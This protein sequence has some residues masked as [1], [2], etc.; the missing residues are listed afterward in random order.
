M[1]FPLS[2]AALV[3][4]LPWFAVFADDVA[5][6]GKIVAKVNGEPI[7]ESELAVALPEGS[8]GLTLDK[9][10]RVKLERMIG[11]R[12]TRQ[13]LRVEKIEIPK[14]DIDKEIQ[15]LKANP[16]AAG[17]S[18]CSYPSLEAF[19]QANF[20]DL[21][22]LRAE[23]ANEL[24]FQKHMAAQWEKDYPPG[25]KRAQLL[26]E[27]RPSLEKDYVKASDIFFNLGEGAE[28]SAKAQAAWRRL[29]KGE[30]F[31][32]VA[33]QVSEDMNS[34]DNGG[35]LGCIQLRFWSDPFKAAVLKLKPGEYSKPVET[36][37][38]FH[39]VRREAITDDDLM[40][41]LKEAL[42]AQ[43]WDKRSKALKDAKVERLGL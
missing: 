36:P 20:Y 23:I 34:R 2:L 16:P 8:F 22:E 29:Q 28:A 25:E 10:K 31:D 6:S 17:C 39:I 35:T 42:A 30:A 26:R 9:A 41:I 5:P 32:A 15:N 40:L 37:N 1:K 18:C 21:E 13:L 7:Y 27:Q 4:C 12:I 33:K 3:A 11:S 14:A 43:G 24:G 19:M 38:G